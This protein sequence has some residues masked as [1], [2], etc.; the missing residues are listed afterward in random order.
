MI[1]QV[2]YFNSIHPILKFYYHHH[3]H[4]SGH[5]P[6][7]YGCSYEDLDIKVSMLFISFYVSAYLD[8]KRQVYE[9]EW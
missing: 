1:P 2:S 3:H 9:K 5:L 4:V 7:N 6:P 8:I